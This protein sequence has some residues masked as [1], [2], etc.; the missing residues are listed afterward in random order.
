MHEAPLPSPLRLA[1]QHLHVHVMRRIRGVERQQARLLGQAGQFGRLEE[2]GTRPI[3][4]HVRLA[5]ATPTRVTVSS[6]ET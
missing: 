6:S 4:S 2:V 5:A 3:R 1:I